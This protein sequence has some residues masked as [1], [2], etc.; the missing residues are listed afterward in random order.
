MD[1]QVGRPVVVGVDSCDRAM[2]AVRWGA[3]EAARRRVPLRV[4]SAF[5]WTEDHVVGQPGLDERDRDILLERVRKALAAAV[6]VATK[7]RPELE[8]CQQLT[9][10][11]PSNVLAAEARRAQLIVVGDQG[12]S[13]AGR[14]LVGSVAVALA[15]QAACP[16]VVIRGSQPPA[17]S[18]LPVVVVGV[19]GSPVSEAAIAFGYQA[20]ADAVC[21]SL[22]CD[23]NEN[24]V[25]RRQ[26]DETRY[27]IRHPGPTREPAEGPG[28][29]GA[30]AGRGRRQRRPPDEHR[31][32]RDSPR[33]GRERCAR[34]RPIPGRAAPQAG[35]Q[36]MHTL[37][38]PH[39][40]VH[41]ENL[42][43]VLD[44]RIQFGCFPMEVRRR[45]GGVLSRGR[46]S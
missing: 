2:D 5:S 24:W 1:T 9:L 29:R 42:D 3:D 33:R 14:L 10:G 38:F 32:Q 15:S 21:R 44:Q 13:R 45:R 8:V 35:L 39:N 7:L 41:V 12:L 17:T 28:P 36:I 34:P 46:P 25:D 18:S 20:A 26:V 40:V 43:E 37:L 16:I 11:L 30:L 27:F 6:D 4:V 31:H 19:D 23:F 22:P